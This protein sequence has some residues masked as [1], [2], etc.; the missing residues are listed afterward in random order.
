M[1]YIRIKHIEEENDL[2]LPVALILHIFHYLFK[3]VVISLP[4][5]AFTSSIIQQHIKLYMV[6]QISRLE[7]RN[8]IVQCLN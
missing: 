8:K 1:Q 4:W 5:S 2:R 6:I 3:L 7:Q